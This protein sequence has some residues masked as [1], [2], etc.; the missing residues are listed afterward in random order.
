MLRLIGCLALGVTLGVVLGAAAG[1][2]VGT[3][4][5]M[6][7][8]E[9]RAGEGVAEDEVPRVLFTFV[10]G[11]V[12][13][14]LGYGAVRLVATLVRGGRAGDRRRDRLSYLESWVVYCLLGAPA[15]CAFVW[16]H[17]LAVVSG[18]VLLSAVTGSLLCTRGGRDQPV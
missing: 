2:N 9:Y 18:A 8:A 10:G 12:G 15:V 17:P 7:S 14:T 6:E 4:R 5:I 11:F 13:G 16:L 1:W 3:H